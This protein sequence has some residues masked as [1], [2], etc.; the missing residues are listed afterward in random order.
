MSPLPAFLRFTVPLILV[1]LSIAQL[2]TADE[3][4]L[5][6]ASRVDAKPV[7]GT[8]TA[9]DAEAATLT[10]ADGETTRIPLGELQELSFPSAPDEAVRPPAAW[11]VTLM[12]GAELLGDLEAPDDDG[13]GVTLA[14]SQAKVR[15]PYDA[16]RHIERLPRDGGHC[17]RPALQHGPEKSKD[18]VWKESSKDRIS[19]TLASADGGGVVLEDERER[20]RRV[21]W[22]EVLVLHLDNDEL[23]E[24]TGVHV[25]IEHRSGSR[26][27]T[28]APPKLVGTGLVFALRAHPKKR[29]TLPLA[30]VASIR[31]SGGTFTYASDL[32]FE[33]TYT[34]FHEPPADTPW[35]KAMVTRL[36]GPRADQRAD[37]CPLRLAGRIYRKGLY[38]HSHSVVRL[39]LDGGYRS[40]QCSFGILD[41]DPGAQMPNRTPEKADVTARVVAD[42]K[43]L[44]EEEGVT[45]A[46][47]A[48]SVGPLDVKGVKVLELIV[49]FG[50]NQ[51]V[52]DD[53]G[54]VNPV[55]VRK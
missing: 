51:D 44:W 34:P 8:L 49:E 31:A 1:L 28:S 33:S 42:G 13:L 39:P 5:A 20:E 52:C 54:W 10:R 53:A 47:G 45:L 11:R 6:T 22:G 14:G 26:L 16:I 35:V 7:R 36:M 18:I 55:L 37:G 32:A 27:T 9:L 29:L 2:G 12:C 3:G 24:P 17:A 40:F 43:T 38:V 15:L 21:A 46:R 41:D 4:D 48:R 23:P 30:E 19:G 50:R 25:E